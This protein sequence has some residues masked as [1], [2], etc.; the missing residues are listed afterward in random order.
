MTA[1]PKKGINTKGRTSCQ[2]QEGGWEKR[3]R[4]A[5]E[6]RKTTKEQEK[7]FQEKK[8]YEKQKIK[9]EVLQLQ[10]EHDML[11]PVATIPQGKLYYDSLFASR[12]T[13]CVLYNKVRVF[14]NVELMELYYKRNITREEIEANRALRKELR[15]RCIHS[16]YHLDVGIGRS[17]DG[18]SG[19]RDGEDDGC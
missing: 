3:V 13:M 2:V 5:D 9:Q 16:N 11:E 15:S 19:H 1:R 14:K 10:K 4:A 7:R 6:T 17:E 8:D 18:S 12:D